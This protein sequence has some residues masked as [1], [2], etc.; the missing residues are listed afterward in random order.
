MA[1]KI[2]S[3]ALV[4]FFVAATAQALE[5]PVVMRDHDALSIS[6]AGDRIADVEALQRPQPVRASDTPAT[7]SELKKPPHP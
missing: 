1:A 3:L 5:E 6:P 7:R 4:G 2:V